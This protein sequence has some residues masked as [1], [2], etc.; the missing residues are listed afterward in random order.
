MG[1]V[2][3][4]MAST[5]IQVYLRHV[6]DSFIHPEVKA[7]HASLNVISLILQQGLVHPVQIVPYL[8][9]MSTD[10]QDMVA[11]TA[12]VQL[13]DIEKKY[14]GFIH[15]KLLQGIRLSH[16]LQEITVQAAAAGA[17]DEEADGRCLIVRG[18][19]VVKEGEM[20]SALNGFLY[21]IMKTTK[22]TRRAI[23]TSLLKQFDDS[24]VRAE[25]PP[26]RTECFGSAT[27]P[28]F[29]CFAEIAPHHDALSR[30]QPCLHSVHGAGRAPLCDTPN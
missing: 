8:M 16:R 13:Q 19:R 28:I 3:S 23:L 2:T 1:D 6:L 27:C 22:Q 11:H 26:F 12:S 24:A 21:S 17:K 7:R 20:P 29:L 9:C 18:C 5:V 25:S 4:G 15:M 14:P 10:S 30:R